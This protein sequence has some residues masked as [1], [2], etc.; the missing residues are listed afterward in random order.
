MKEKLNDKYL[1]Q[2]KKLKSQQLH[3]RVGLEQKLLEK[4]KTVRVF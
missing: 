1:K 2:V 3:Q 4:L